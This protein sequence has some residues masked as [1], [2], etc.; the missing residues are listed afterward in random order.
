MDFSRVGSVAELRSLC[1]EGRLFEI[2]LFPEEFGGLH[3]PSNVAYVP[4][5]IPE[6]RET[7]LGTLVR[8]RR[9]GAI[10]ELDVTPEYKGGSLVPSKIT[11][12]AWHSGNGGGELR[13]SLD[14]W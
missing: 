7:V 5:G 1:E 6:A 11:M 10:D 14:I 9:E 4:R 3:A 8:L 2:L 12:R 13:V